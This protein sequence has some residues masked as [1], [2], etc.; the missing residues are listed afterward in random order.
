MAL[1]SRKSDHQ[2]LVIEM[3]GMVVNQPV[4]VLID[5][6]YNFRYLSPKA[7][8]KY[9]FPRKNHADLWIAK[10]AM[11]VKNQVTNQVVSCPMELG[12]M[13]TTVTLNLFPLGS[14]DIL[15]SMD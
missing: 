6:R 4:L 9:S 3:E 2:A 7:I 1:D 12:G 13:S 5:L 8:N 14:Y 11:R 10:I 15:I